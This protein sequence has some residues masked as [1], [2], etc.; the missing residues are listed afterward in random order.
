[1]CNSV[2][3]LNKLKHQIV[4]AD[5]AMGTLL[6]SYGIG[7]CIEELN[8][9]Q[10]NQI[11]D[12]HRA[13]IEAGAQVIQTNTYGA[14]AEKLAPYGLE[15]DVKHIN[16][17]AVRLA[18]RAVHQFDNEQRK[19]QSLNHQ[20]VANHERNHVSKLESEHESEHAFEHRYVLG[21]IGGIRGLPGKAIP[22]AHIERLFYEQLTSL[23]EE[24]VDGIILETYYDL[25]ELL[26]VLSIAR[27]ETE[28][29]IITQLSLQD[30]G[31]VQGGVN[32][33]D[34]FRMLEQSGADVI[35]LNCRHGPYH[36]VR[37]LERIPIPSDAYLSVYPNA[38]L[39]SYQNGR[40][41]YLPNASYFSE[42]AVLLW[43][44]GARLI[45]GCC[46]TTPEH[47]RVMVEALKGKT[48]V[49]HKH[50]TTR[51]RPVKEHRL[52]SIDCT[53]RMDVSVEALHN[54]SHFSEPS[55][56]SSLNELPKGL[57][58]VIVELDPPKKLVTTKFYE[59]V[60][61]LKKAGINALTLADNSL[62]TPRICNVSLATTVKDKYNVH[63]LVHL[64]C[65]DRNIIGLQS[66]VMGLSTLGLNNILAITGDPAKVGSFPGATS[67]YDLTS[68]ELIQLIKQCNE[69]LSFTGKQLGA[70]TTFNV[71]AAFNPNVRSLEKAVQRM[72][73]KIV[74][75][76]DYFLTQPV[77]SEAVIEDVFEYTKHITKPVYLGIMPLTSYR[78]AEFLHHEVPGIK[79][80]DD[81]RQ[82]MARHEHDKKQ[83]MREGITI[84]KQ[85]IDTALTYFDGIYL[86]TPFMNY[87]MTVELT[88]YVREKSGEIGR[89]T[90]LAQSATSPTSKTSAK[91]RKSGKQL[92]SGK[93]DNAANPDKTAKAGHTI[94]K[95]DNMQQP[96]TTR[97][98]DASGVGGSKHYGQNII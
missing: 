37:S 56:Y 2:E 66:H 79:L 50:V 95:Q 32:V 5:G 83:A 89:T 24:G 10:P 93:V 70:K 74:A 86:I 97:T 78:N 64:T 38:S 84:A 41:H 26:T 62:A 8:L 25:E 34:A 12:I 46:G 13:Y 57:K 19:K 16:K 65:R 94:D 80:A 60:Q 6:Y 29:P 58:K 53:N 52:S 49:S 72:E 30:V 73:K 27:L 76:A 59:G 14:N 96:S 4:I 54:A 71:G 63:P 92:N 68:I 82:V 88:E 61:A 1:M 28:L 43:E 9:S 39:P 36:M 44:Q 87:E 3:L 31:V 20:S 51:E 77:Y 40:Y 90:N 11:V 85:L 7:S 47:I 35:G 42:M 33:A 55:N 17:Q 48:P 45:G 81:V 98:I 67:V 21:T 75:G 22:L 18:K 91:S 15:T 23:L 69:G